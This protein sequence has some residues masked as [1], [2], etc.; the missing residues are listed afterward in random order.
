MNW[1][2]RRYDIPQF[3][4]KKTVMGIV[5]TLYGCLTMTVGSTIILLIKYLPLHLHLLYT[6][7]ANVKGLF[8]C[9]TFAIFPFWVC[10]IPLVLGM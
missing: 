8:T 5:L 10:G 1:N 7:L 3:G 2:G 6:Y 4:F 9:K